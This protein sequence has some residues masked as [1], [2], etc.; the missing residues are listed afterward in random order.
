MYNE[1]YKTEVF[2]SDEGDLCF[3]V[4]GCDEIRKLE[5]YIETNNIELISILTYEMY[6]SNSYKIGE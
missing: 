4:Y 3:V 2:E 6:E 5:E 1:I